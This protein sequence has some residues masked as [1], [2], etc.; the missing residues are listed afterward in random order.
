MAPE[1]GL[2]LLKSYRFDEVLPLGLR[3]LI[4][5]GF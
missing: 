2:R 4:Q 1:Y 5:V 3:R